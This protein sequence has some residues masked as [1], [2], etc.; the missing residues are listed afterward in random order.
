M[1]NN[2]INLNNYKTLKQGPTRQ[3]FNGAIRLWQTQL[4]DLRWD[5]IRLS[6]VKT[7]KERDNQINQLI[8][9][10]YDYSDIFGTSWTLMDAI[11]PY[12]AEHL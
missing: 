6:F 11:K 12:E 8:N 9:K 10:T 1:S 4:S 3:Q 5:I 2:E 7:K